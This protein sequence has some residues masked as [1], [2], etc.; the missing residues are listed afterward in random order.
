M[1]AEPANQTLKTRRTV[2]ELWDKHTLHFA[3]ATNTHLHIQRLQCEE[4]L[5]V[6]FSACMS[7][8]ADIHVCV[9]VY[10]CVQLASPNPRTQCLPVLPLDSSQISHGASCITSSAFPQP[11]MVA[12]GSVLELT[13]LIIPQQTQPYKLQGLFWIQRGLVE[14]F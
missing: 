8:C 6:E 5:Q 2:W 1:Y 9:C 3:L 12:L 4:G 7:V 13:A 11:L 14:S 10:V